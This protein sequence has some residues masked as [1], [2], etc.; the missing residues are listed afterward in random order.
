MIDI[1]EPG[2]E[3]NVFDYQRMAYSVVEEMGRR[4]VL[5]I[6]VGGS[7]LYLESVLC[8]Y[9]MVP[10]AASPALREELAGFGMDDLR[11]R[12]IAARPRQHNVTDQLDRERIYR[13]IEIAEGEKA[14]LAELP[15]P[16]AV[17]AVILGIRLPR[18]ELRERITRRLKERLDSGMIEE[19]EGLLASGV[20]HERL[21]FYGLE[22]RFISRMLNGELDRE[23]MFSGLNQAIHKFAKRQE[24]WF[25]RM[26][27]KGLEIIW[28]DAGP[29]LEERAMQA[30][31]GVSFR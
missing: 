24:T 25:R 22:Y 7:G 17:D 6:L 9:R 31:A 29:G 16:P 13:A 3:F 26:E 20:A 21:A 18:S 5:P 23:A 11:T 10:V 12:L 2:T 27:K 14:L 4:G 28:L 8:G 19:V 30:L 15:P 1:V